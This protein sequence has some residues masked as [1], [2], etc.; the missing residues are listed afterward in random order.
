MPL[1]KIGRKNSEK[2]FFEKGGVSFF[3][4]EKFPEKNF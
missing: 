4:S 3:L 1:R 2:N